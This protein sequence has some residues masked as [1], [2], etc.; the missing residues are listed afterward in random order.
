MA[1]KA[2]TLPLCPAQNSAEKGKAAPASKGPSSEKVSAGQLGKIR[3]VA[4][5]KRQPLEGQIAKLILRPG[6]FLFRLLIFC[7]CRPGLRNIDASIPAAGHTSRLCAP[8]TDTHGPNTAR[9]TGPRSC[10]GRNASTRPDARLN[11]TKKT[12]WSSST[13]LCGNPTSRTRRAP[14]D[15]P[16]SIPSAAGRSSS[17]ARSRRLA[18]QH[19]R[20]RP[21]PSSA[22][23]PTSRSSWSS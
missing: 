20:A 16:R 10:G 11:G 3:S 21:R 5:G 23:W 18:H 12:G 1:K 9:S 19:P 14:A 13:I 22:R 6:A 8:R 2:A 4:Q 7:S 17:G 15:R